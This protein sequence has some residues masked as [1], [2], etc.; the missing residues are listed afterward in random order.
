LDFYVKDKIYKYNNWI[1][2]T[3]YFTIYILYFNK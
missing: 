3:L 1:Y 2:I